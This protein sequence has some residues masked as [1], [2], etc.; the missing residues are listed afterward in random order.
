ME[1][2]VLLAFVCGI[3]VVRMLVSSKTHVL[4][5]LRSSTPAPGVGHCPSSGTVLVP[6]KVEG[7]AQRLVMFLVAAS[8]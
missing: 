7:S 5:F 3:T 4:V 8:C 1:G 2:T 6:E